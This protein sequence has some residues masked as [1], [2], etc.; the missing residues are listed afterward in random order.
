MTICH[1]LLTPRLVDFSQVS[2]TYGQG[3]TAEWTM[4]KQMTSEEGGMWL[5]LALC[6][7]TIAIALT[8]AS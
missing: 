2:L 6:F 5:T 4:R 1:P 7:L 3:Y 8:S